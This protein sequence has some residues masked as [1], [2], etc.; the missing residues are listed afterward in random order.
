MKVRGTL[1]LLALVLLTGSLLAACGGS[2][3]ECNC[4]V[5]PQVA[6]APTP[7]PTGPCTEEWVHMPVLIGF[8]TGGA[9]IDAQNRAIL[10]E[11]VS[12]A[13]SRT[14]IRRVRVEGHADT[15]GQEVNNTAL[16]TARADTVAAELV[17]MG[18]PREMLE[19]VG[20]GSTQPRA[21]EAC[22]RRRTD[23]L[24]RQTNRRVEFSILVCREGTAGGM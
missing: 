22:E 20:Y 8:P 14:D 2:C 15:C 12:T 17:T 6:V 19:T 3:P 5:C 24:S 9:E 13:R 1:S 23:E 7:Q 21:N 18:V 4:P 10:Q 16:S 11:V